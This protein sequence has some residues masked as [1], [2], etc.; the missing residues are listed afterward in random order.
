[1]IAVYLFIQVILT[2]VKR[3]R[4]EWI[5]HLPRRSLAVGDFLDD[6]GDISILLPGAFFTGR[7][8][9]YS[10]ATVQLL[11]HKGFNFNLNS[12]LTFILRQDSSQ[13]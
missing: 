4:A 10:P 12:S 11:V 1:M 9:C 8:H 13:V 2:S 5:E 6:M 3:S 7:Q